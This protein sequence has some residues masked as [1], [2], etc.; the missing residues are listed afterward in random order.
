[1]G[2]R[3]GGWVGVRSKAKAW[4]RRGEGGRRRER[5]REREMSERKGFEG[6]YK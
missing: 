2:G 5:E 6:L 4:I 1:M 3:V